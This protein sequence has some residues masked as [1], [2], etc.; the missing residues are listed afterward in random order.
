M[1]YF[2]L[3]D[4]YEHMRNAALISTSEDFINQVGSESASSGEPYKVRCNGGQPVTSR[5]WLNDELARFRLSAPSET[6]QSRL[7]KPR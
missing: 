2:H 7:I 1:A 6:E 5:Q 3:R 4:K